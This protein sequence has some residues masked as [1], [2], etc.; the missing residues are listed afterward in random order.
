MAPLLLGARGFMWVP[1]GDPGGFLPCDF[2]WKAS[3]CLPET[4]FSRGCPGI[5]S[6]LPTSALVLDLALQ[7]SSTPCP[8]PPP[9]GHKGHR[10]RAWLPSLSQ[11]SSSWLVTSIH[12]SLSSKCH[13]LTWE[14]LDSPQMS[15]HEP[16]PYPGSLPSLGD[17]CVLRPTRSLARAS[18]SG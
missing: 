7:L 9:S 10:V 12:A 15:V 17:L 18:I 8:W 1:R 3:V 16:P 6:S 14:R 2:S 4:R 11:V 5:T 13:T